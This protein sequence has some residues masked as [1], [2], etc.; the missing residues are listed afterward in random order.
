MFLIII[1]ELLYYH[2]LLLFSGESKV[3]GPPSPSTKNHTTVEERT[4]V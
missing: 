2:D 4:K 1:F 3:A